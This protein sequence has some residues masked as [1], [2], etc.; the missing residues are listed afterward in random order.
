MK[1]SFLGFYL[2][3]GLR[4]LGRADFSFI[5]STWAQFFDYDFYGDILRSEKN[6]STIEKEN[7]SK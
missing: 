6:K 3:K 2:K 7:R 5:A 1:L 4:P